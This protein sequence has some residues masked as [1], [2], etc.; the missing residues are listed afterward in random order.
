M[1][2]ETTDEALSAHQKQLENIVK[3]CLLPG[4]NTPFM[5]LGR[6]LEGYRKDAKNFFGRLKATDGS[7][8]TIR[9]LLEHLHFRKQILLRLDTWIKER[10]QLS[11]DDVLARY[12]NKI[13][14][15]LDQVPA[16]WV[17]DQPSDRFNS[18]PGDQIGTRIIKSIK[19]TGYSISS[20]T[21]KAFNLLK[22]PFGSRPG[23]MPTWK[24]RLAVRQITSWY[25]EVILPEK[26]GTILHSAHKKVACLASDIWV[27]DDNLY[28][29]IASS[30]K[31]TT[32][33]DSLTDTC[34]RNIFSRLESTQQEIEKELTNFEARLDVVLNDTASLFHKQLVLSGTL[35]YSVFRHL[36]L[37]KKFQQKRNRKTLAL[38]ISKRL[39]TLFALADDWKFN[40]EIYLLA[41]KAA[42]ANL[43]FKSRLNKRA[44][45]IVENIDLIP[46]FLNQTK[47]RLL[48][49]TQPTH[50]ESV[51]KH[52]Q[53]LKYLAGKTLV[54]SIITGVTAKFLQ[55]NFPVLIDELEKE[56]LSELA[57]KTRKRYLIPDFDPV[58]DYSEKTLQSISLTELVEF[59]I[60]SGLTQVFRRA[61][62]QSIQEFQTLNDQFNDV[63]R[64][65]LFN[66]ETS[67]VMLDQQGEDGIEHAIKDTFDALE[68][69]S[70]KT[71]DQ[72]KGFNHFILSLQTSLD[73]AIDQFTRSLLGLTDNTKVEKIRFRIMKAR[74]MKKKAQLSNSLIGTGKTIVEKGRVW[75]R[76]V[77]RKSSA[78]LR[79]IRGQLGLK[80]IAGDISSEVSDFLVAD[81]EKLQRFPFVYRRLFAN[82]PLTDITF[83]FQRRSEYYQLLGAFNKWKEGSFAPLLILGEKGSGISTL[84]Q[85]FLKDQAL[86]N[87]RIYQFM[88]VTR[89]LSEE[90]LLSQLGKCFKGQAFDSIRDFYEFINLHD[91]FVVF[92]DKIHL[93]YLR[94]P[95]GFKLINRFFELISHT[96]RK[97]FWLLSCNLYASL[98]LNNAIGL[99][100]YFPNLIFIQ[101][102]NLEDVKKLILMR[103]NASGYYLNFIPSPENMN[104][105]QY[106]NKNESEKQKYLQNRYFDTLQSMTQSNISFALQLWLRSAKKTEDNTIHIQSIDNID[107]SF[108][109]SLTDEV[110]FGMH[111]LILHEFMDVAQI[112]QV[113]NVSQRQAYLLL[114]RLKDRGIVFEENG[115][116]SIHPLLYRQTINILKDKNLIH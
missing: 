38:M 12:E 49:K 61:K 88:P 109:H 44:E 10:E 19:R 74:A 62:T 71:D 105:K 51:R 16:Y 116:F 54:N 2:T 11:T 25:Y 45:E 95:G 76:F 66:I 48:T 86:R 108:V 96:S 4:L 21:L 80:A 60:A 43:Q 85:F 78:G 50:I 47:E 41:I 20:V 70:R 52:L 6:L 65:V 94:H 18:L 72:K 98:Y 37:R 112:A 34:F 27:A 97:V 111:A 55:Q 91:P 83:Y 102:L 30:H 93:F 59:E 42:K 26:Y 9:M 115:Y 114:M 103:H 92:V 73:E 31:R 75:N 46:V 8:H 79:I 29:E 99:Y 87:T 40:Q 68:R 81:K 5:R 56:L 35:E 84:L 58:I 32:D 39:N 107:L 17:I 22:V 113:L 24:Q 57:T 23:P 90:D 1:K 14:D 104:E 69:A 110:V 106:L 77:R 15:L 36:E 7:E 89:V 3:E 53:L 13:H 67:I 28:E 63:G 100:G 33:V 64:M 82:E 101:K